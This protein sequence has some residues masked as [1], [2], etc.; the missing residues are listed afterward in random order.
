MRGERYD[1][2]VDVLVSPAIPRHHTRA[3]F[4]SDL[5]IVVKVAAEKLHKVFEVLLG[6]SIAQQTV[7][8]SGGGI[9]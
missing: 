2:T 6:V 9:R 8:D 1:G 4:S 5:V 3:T 7:G